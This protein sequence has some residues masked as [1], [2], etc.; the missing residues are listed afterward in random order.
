VRVDAEPRPPEPTG[1]EGEKGKW[2]QTGLSSLENVAVNREPL[3][4]L[5]E[6]CDG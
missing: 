3:R 2:G 5:E 6:G 1:C 4:V